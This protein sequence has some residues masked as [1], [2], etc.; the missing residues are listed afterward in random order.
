MRTGPRRPES[1]FTLVELAIVIVIIGILMSFL[2]AASWDGVRR[3]NERATQSLI[4]KLDVAVADRIESLTT[5]RI[6]PNN[7][8]HFLAMS[9]LN[10]PSGPRFVESEARARLI[11]E[12][13][14]LRRE[15]PDVFF[16]QADPNYPLNFAGV[17]FKPRSIAPNPIPSQ[18]VFPP[19][20]PG[21]PALT[22]YV[23]DILPLG[24]AVT[25]NARYNASDKTF[26]VATPGTRL[27]AVAGLSEPPAP[28]RRHFRHPDAGEGIFG[29]SYAAI[30]SLTKQL[31]YPPRGYNGVDDDGNGLID[32][33]TASE[34]FLPG[35]S[36]AFAPLQAEILAK[37]QAHQHITARS[38]ML[39][40]ILV[41]GVGPLGSVFSPDDFTDREVQDTDGDGLPEFV[42]AWG[43]PLQFYRWPTYF[44]SNYGG[45]RGLQKG[46]GNYSPGNLSEP[47]EENP[48]D[49]NQLLVSP[50]WWA[51]PEPIADT[52]AQMSDRA[53]AFQQQFF[54]LVDPLAD[55]PSGSRTL[56]FANRGVL[57]DRSNYYKRR[58]YFFKH[59]ILS[60]G[61]DRQYGVGTYGVEYG[62]SEQ[63]ILRG[64]P[65]A[66]WPDPAAAAS[67]AARMVLV[68]NQAA[69]TD[70]GAR[71]DEPFSV[72]GNAGTA[73]IAQASDPAQ[74]M[75]LYQL[76]STSDPAR[77]ADQDAT[78]LIQERWGLDDITNHAI[79][80]TGSGGR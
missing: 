75:A 30:G 65:A 35:D 14:Y 70:P 76:P 60:A 51:N 66:N 3:A 4:L 20:F 31:G 16:V 7:A 54:S 53:N 9:Y 77:T 36:A 41:N 48:L 17:P 52:S 21:F 27:G 18:T 42:D 61:P 57:W 38:E 72:P 45:G 58:A 43:R 10:T 29:A 80:S 73:T 50:A 67:N 68:E 2:L 49:P 59:L 55:D 26:S 22:D 37:L 33:F 74:R 40:A 78:P 13:D 46:S 39:Y 64:Q 63:T 11:A 34:L 44:A 8:H 47:R 12:I 1:G 56:P 71:T 79:N 15:L 5:Q 69:R 23:F 6:Q 32:E 25:I 24:H 19:P 62:D 28:D